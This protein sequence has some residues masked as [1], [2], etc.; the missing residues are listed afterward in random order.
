MKSQHPIGWIWSPH[1]RLGRGGYVDA[2]G[3]CCVDC[4]CCHYGYRIFHR[5]YRTY[6]RIRTDA[7]RFRSR[8]NPDDDG[9][10]PCGHELDLPQWAKTMAET[11]V[12]VFPFLEE[13]AA[14]EAEEFTRRLGLN[15]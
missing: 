15:E 6:E 2:G 14:V 7:R 8:W 1:G 10:C 13:R 12:D 9:N 3:I 5:D 11:M 4:E